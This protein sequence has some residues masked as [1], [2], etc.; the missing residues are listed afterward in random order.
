MH[1]HAEHD[2]RD[3]HRNQL[4]EGIAQYL[5]ADGEIGGGHPEHDPQQQRGKNLNEQGGI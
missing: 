5:Q 3:D 1:H 4:Q 2:R